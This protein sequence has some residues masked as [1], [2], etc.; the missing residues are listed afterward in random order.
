MSKKPKN[1]EWKRAHTKKRL[2]IAL[3][4]ASVCWFGWAPGLISFQTHSLC[5]ESTVQYDQPTMQG[6]WYTFSHSQKGAWHQR[7]TDMDHRLILIKTESIY[8]HL[9]IEDVKMRCQKQIFIL[10]HCNYTLRMRRINWT[11]WPLI[12]ARQ[13]RTCSPQPAWHFPPI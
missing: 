4:I 12:S 13:T 1:E 3:K 11:V 10:N 9:Q 2:W 6:V 5:L 8:G 7:E